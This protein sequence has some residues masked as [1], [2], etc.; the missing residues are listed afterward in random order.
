MFLGST[1]QLFEC[2]F[3]LWKPPI[4]LTS[5]V[6]FHPCSQ[7]PVCSLTQKH[8]WCQRERMLLLYWRP[9]SQ[10]TRDL[11]FS[12]IQPMILP[13]VS[14][15]PTQHSAVQMILFLPVCANY[16][17]YIILCKHGEWLCYIYIFIIHSE[18]ILIVLNAIVVPIFFVSLYCM[19]WYS[20]P[21][22]C[23]F[24]ILALHAHLPNRGGITLQCSIFL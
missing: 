5:L 1:Q 4:L 24:I 2:A 20:A 14:K 9:T 3:F 22:A 15:A 10:W 21:A 6:L 11:A 7:L 13:T 23:I 18:C 12:S 19:N 17:H 8:T 16:G